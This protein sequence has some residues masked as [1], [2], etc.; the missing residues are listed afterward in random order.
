[1]ADR[2]YHHG[3]LRRALIEAAIELVEDNG[4]SG[5]SL[6]EAARRVG[7][8]SGAPYRHFPNK[9]ALV[10]AVAEE[11]QARQQV[12]LQEVAA[13]LEPGLLSAFRAYAMA[14]AR[15]ATLHPNLYRLM[16][17]PEVM[18]LATEQ[19]KQ[20]A[21]AQRAQLL[22][23]LRQAQASGE[24]AP[25]PVEAQL[26]AGQALSDGLLHMVA[27]GQ[28]ELM[29]VETEGRLEELMLQVTQVLLDGLAPR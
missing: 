2:P 15:I 20:G 28:M 13:E 11:L 14:G 21:M 10:V 24:L 25:G 23:L 22:E 12:I 4:L 16:T 6:R 1:M 17:S 18:D 26:L 29:G 3:D 8:S 19:W 7:V 27:S 9:D 5:L